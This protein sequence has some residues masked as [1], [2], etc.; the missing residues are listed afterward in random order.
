MRW[1][2]GEAEQLRTRRFGRFQIIERIQRELRQTRV[3]RGQCREELVQT[4]SLRAHHGLQLL[5]VQN[6]APILRSGFSSNHLVI[7]VNR[8]AQF[9]RGLPLSATIQTDLGVVVGASDQAVMA[10]CL[11][12]SGSLVRTTGPLAHAQLAWAAWTLSDLGRESV[13]RSAAG[14]EPTG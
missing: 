6:H 8:H 13:V 1:A 12:R 3:P 7:T 14:Q 4:L 2:E 5:T 9:A 11:A 10:D